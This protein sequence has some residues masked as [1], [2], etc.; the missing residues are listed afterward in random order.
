ME[1]LPKKWEGMRSDYPWEMDSL[2]SENIG[3][4][5][6]QSRERE[7]LLGRLARKMEDK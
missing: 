1:Y 6:P 7:K 5:L 2:I 4:R 3:E